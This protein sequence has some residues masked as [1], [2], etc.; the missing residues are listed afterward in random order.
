MIKS[1][2]VKRSTMEES[3]D[4]AVVPKS[5]KDFDFNKIDTS[6]IW[7]PGDLL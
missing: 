5:I 1:P 4:I 6:I 2:I 3:N 7:I